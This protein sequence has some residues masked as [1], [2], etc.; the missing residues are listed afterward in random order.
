[1]AA[2][3]QTKALAAVRE[4][5]GQAAAPPAAAR[6]RSRRARRGHGR[7]A[8]RPP[9]RRLLRARPCRGAPLRPACCSCP[10]RDTCTPA[11]TLAC[12]A[13]SFRRACI[14]TSC[15]RAWAA[16]V[17]RCTL[18]QRLA[19]PGQLAAGA[20]RRAAQPPR[21]ARA[22]RGARAPAGVDEQ[23]AAAHA[24]EEVAVHDAARGR[25]QRQQHDDHVRARQ[26]RGQLCAARGR[27]RRLA[28]SCGTRHVRAAR[29]PGASR[30]AS[31]RRM[32][33]GGIQNLSQA[34]QPMK[35]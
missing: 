35:P 31:T 21:A 10:A 22:W 8:A 34:R 5:C 30:S 7:G 23:R 16:R 20:A 11:C 17:Q 2:G 4:R 3:G 6:G 9:A 19:A 13:W 12:K 15:P 14:W 18:A 28:D 32:R 27:V 25:R 33:A 29:S 1:M 24:A 26:Q